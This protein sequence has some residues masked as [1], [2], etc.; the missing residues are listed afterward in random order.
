MFYS[1]VWKNKNNFYYHTK[2]NDKKLRVI[3][4]WSPKGWARSCPK[5]VSI[6][7][8]W[9]RLNKIAYFFSSRNWIWVIFR[10][11]RPWCYWFTNTMSNQTMKKCW[12]NNPNSRPT[13]PWQVSKLHAHMK[14]MWKS[15]KLLQKLASWPWVGIVLSNYHFHDQ[16]ITLMLAMFL[17]VNKM[18]TSTELRNSNVVW[19]S[20]CTPPESPQIKIWNFF[21]VIQHMFCLVL[22][23]HKMC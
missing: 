14:T 17:G 15:V 5:Y 11:F 3:I 12:D 20:Y 19:Q 13:H 21:P 9:Y 6:W 23:F 16:E 2:T 22:R 1:N 4:K 10:C 18:A 8:N 7:N